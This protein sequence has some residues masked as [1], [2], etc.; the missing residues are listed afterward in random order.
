MNDQQLF[1][2]PS[3]MSLEAIPVMYS[4]AVKRYFSLLLPLLLMVLVKHADLR[5]ITLLALLV[6]LVLPMFATIMK[7]LSSRYY[8]KDGRLI[9]S[10]GM[11]YT[12]TQFIPLDKIHATRTHESPVYRLFDMVGIYF[13]T[14]KDEQSEVE[15]VLNRDDWARLLDAVSDIQVKQLDDDEARVDSVK[16]EA[17]VN[18][19]LGAISQ[20]FLVKVF[21]M[22]IVGVWYLYSQASDLLNIFLEEIENWAEGW[23]AVASSNYEALS[24]ISIAILLLASYLIMMLLWIARVYIKYYNIKLEFTD[25]QL[26]YSAGLLTRVTNKFSRDKITVVEIKQNIVEK[27]LNLSTITLRQAANVA[28][29]KE[30]NEI[31]VYGCRNAAEILNW[32]FGTNTSELLEG[33]DAVSG[34]GYFWRNIFI[35]PLTAVLVVL[36]LA[37]IADPHPGLVGAIITLLIYMP[38]RALVMQHHSSISLRHDY[39]QIIHGRFARR[40]SYVRYGEPED[41]CVRL[42][43]LGRYTHSCHLTISTRGP[44]FTVRSIK[45][46]EALRIYN[47][48]LDSSHEL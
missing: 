8:I 32:T 47:R 3:R 37:E 9:F 48:Q 21:A 27:F 18:L 17:K 25:D 23:L 41:V 40:T 10:H 6:V 31:M 29:K 12:Q 22:V 26:S 15:L 45:L 46:D 28:G 13:D 7:F 42:T 5:Q 39:I 16:V 1:S 14:L 19:I 24:A 30:E 35:T 11:L 33:M 44:K 2:T 43:L 38:V 36:L 4:R 20:N 34:R